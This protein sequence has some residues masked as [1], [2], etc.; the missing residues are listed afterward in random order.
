M[1]HTARDGDE[2]E[3]KKRKAEEDRNINGSWEER[4]MCS[5]RG[6]EEQ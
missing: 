5:G 3:K 6:E 2:S 1:R 4:E